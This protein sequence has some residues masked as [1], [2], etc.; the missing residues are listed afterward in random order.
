[1]PVRCAAIVALG[2]FA[3]PQAFES[4][5]ACLA[6]RTSLECRH[7]V[8]ALVALGDP[9]RRDPF[10]EALKT[11]VNPLVRFELIKAL[12]VFLDE[13]V[14]EALIQRLTDRDEDVRATAAVALGKMGQSRAIP[15]LQRMALTDTNQETT[16]HGL[17]TLNSSVAKR[18]IQMILHPEQEHDLD[19]PD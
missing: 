19:W 4:L 6:A 11:E 2:M 10:L 9:R 3:D 14:L 8:Q 1:M 7:A 18:A 15:A 17:Y 16:I 5:V 12:S 13:E